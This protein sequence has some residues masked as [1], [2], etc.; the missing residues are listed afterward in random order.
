MKKRCAYYNEIE[1]HLQFLE[2]FGRE[3]YE[4][5]DDDWHNVPIR[6]FV[7]HQDF[8]IQHQLTVDS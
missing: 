8:A 6:D 4:P 5:Q 3:E 2:V 1:G 7:E